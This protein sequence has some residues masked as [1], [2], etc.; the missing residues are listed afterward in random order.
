MINE[1]IEDVY[2]HPPADA[3][4]SAAAR[5]L[6]T[7]EDYA[8]NAFITA[9]GTIMR[10]LRQP[11]GERDQEKLS[12]ARQQVT[13]MLAMIDG[14]LAGRQWLVGNFSLADVA[15]APRVAICR[16]S[17]SRSIRSRRTSPPGSS[18]LPARQHPRPGWPFEL[19]L[20]SGRPTR[21]APVRAAG[22]VASGT[23]VAHAS[24]PRPPFRE[25]A[26][27]SRRPRTARDRC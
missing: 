22:V 27:G 20:V 26:S 9:T 11:E 6:R 16:R 24:S 19:A 23:A 18:A 5:A 25:P 1:Y 10:E 4:D 14:S 3:G 21:V 7:F 2:P 17:G 15:F 8:D 13:R 12:T